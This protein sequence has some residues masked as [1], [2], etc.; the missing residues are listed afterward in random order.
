MTKLE[1]RKWMLRRRRPLRHSGFVILSSF[2]I[3]I[4]SFSLM[5]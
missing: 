5:A 1:I 3:L 2:V 4:S